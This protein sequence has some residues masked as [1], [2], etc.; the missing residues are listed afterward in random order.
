MRSDHGI[1]GHHPWRGALGPEVWPARL[2]AMSS[3]QSDAVHA[4]REAIDQ[5]D[6]FRARLSASPGYDDQARGRWSLLEP[7]VDADLSGRRVLVVACDGSRWFATR[8]PESVLAAASWES[9]DA[10]ELGTFDIVYC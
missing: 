2:A 10:A 7:H 1:T 9:L 3:H 5:L 6:A 4:L 8:N